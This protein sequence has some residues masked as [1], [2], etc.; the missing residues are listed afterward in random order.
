MT[1]RIMNAIKDNMIVNPIIKFLASS[2]NFSKFIIAKID[3]QLYL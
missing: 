3:S 2:F 1:K